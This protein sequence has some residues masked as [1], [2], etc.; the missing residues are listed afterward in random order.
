MIEASGSPHP[1]PTPPNWKLKPEKFKF[2]PNWMISAHICPETACVFV[3]RHTDEEEFL[4][5]LCSLS[6]GPHRGA[7]GGAGN[8]ARHESQ[9]TEQ[10]RTT[11]HPHN[12]A[13]PQPCTPTTM[14]PH[15]PQDKRQMSL[16]ADR[17]SEACRRIQIN[18]HVGRLGGCIVHTPP[19]GQHKLS[20]P[21]IIECCCS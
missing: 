13:P 15:K 21:V 19:P 10:K 8:R 20:A 11:M 9:G 16:R 2:S 6:S 12:H 1:P 5:P 7:G 18:G 14:H 4:K 17:Q 3:L